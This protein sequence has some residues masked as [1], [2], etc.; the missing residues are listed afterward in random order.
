MKS[1]SLSS[2]QGDFAKAC[3]LLSIHAVNREIKMRDGAS[4]FEGSIPYY[5]DKGP[6]KNAATSDSLTTGSD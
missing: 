5:H 4:S 1:L 6:T 2:V 3:W